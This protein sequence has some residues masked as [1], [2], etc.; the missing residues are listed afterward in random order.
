MRRFI[1]SLPLWLTASALLIA[2][3]LPVHAQ[4]RGDI[5][6][7]ELLA[8]P[9]GTILDA[10]GEW[11]ELFNATPRPIN[12]Q[13]WAVRDSAASGLRPFHIINTS[14][15]I[16][17]FGFVV[18][19]NTTNTTNN[20]GVPVDYA[21]GVA[22]SFANSLDRIQIFLP[23]Q[24]T[25]ISEAYYQSA[26]AS[27]QNGVSRERRAIT[28][29]S[30]GIPTDISKGN[31]MDGPNWIDPTVSTVYGPGGR[32][33]PK[34]A[35]QTVVPVAATATTSAVAGYRLIAP[36][37]AG[38][39]VGRLAELNLVQ[40]LPDEFPNAAGPNLFTGYT[41]GPGPYNGYT[42]PAGKGDVLTLGRGAFWMMYTAG[43]PGPNNTEGTSRRADLPLTLLAGGYPLAAG[44]ATTFT[45]ADRPGATNQ[46]YLLG[47][48]FNTSFDLSGLTASSGTFSE[49]FQFYDP[50]NGFTVRTRVAGTSDGDPSDDAAVWEGFFA[51][52]FAAP[53]LPVTLTY[54]APVA[55]A[56]RPAAP[57][58]HVGLVLDGVT[59][60]GL[61][62]HDE[63]A[64]L[65]F[66]EGATEAWDAYDASK[67]TPPDAAAALL[68]PVGPGADGV[69]KALAQLSLPYSLLAP[70]TVPLALTAAAGTY[71]LT[72]ATVEGVPATWQVSL[73]DHAT[74]AVTALSVGVSYTFE[75]A[76]V[77][78]SERFSLTVF[79]GATTASEPGVGSAYALTA[80]APNPSTSGARTMLQVLQAQTVRAEV[81]DVLG[82]RVQTV[83]AGPV[84]AG[85][86]QVLDVT[87]A[88]LPAGTYVLRVTGAD[89][90]ATQTF[91]VVR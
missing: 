74:G 29:L 52:F 70:V 24:K 60:A 65:Y 50:T 72:A 85:A 15:V 20:G 68:A 41:G 8:N 35:G 63:A 37:F 73:T 40:G 14:L 53:V 17:P 46:F 43:G 18:L 45:A 71:T 87:S 1:D 3:A 82:R 58:R 16:P 80:V 81:Y 48:P 5:V 75:S 2:L 69:A 28:N 61:P 38:I 47:N 6:V 25:R 49:V 66:T 64:G 33:T 62:A 4:S 30:S 31:Q 84:A 34:A 91:S 78:A 22:F 9:G 79:P 32:G 86:S 67:L 59:A 90:A 23:D 39:T 51:E 44:V 56:G 54:A 27:A 57:S 77:S 11:F 88:A 36:P 19:G 13:G 76:A 42:A 12:L 83:F 10:S 89:F 55:V 21:Y 26:A 7:T